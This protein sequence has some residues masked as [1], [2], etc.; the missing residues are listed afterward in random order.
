MVVVV[1]LAAIAVVVV[2]D[3]LFLVRWLLPLRFP[4]KLYSFMVLPVPEIYRIGSIQGSSFRR[5]LPPPSRT[6]GSGSFV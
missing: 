1:L 2:D 3:V 6:D 4:G 5:G